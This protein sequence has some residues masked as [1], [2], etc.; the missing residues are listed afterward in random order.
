M[1]KREELDLINLNEEIDNFFESKPQKE[2]ENNPTDAVSTENSTKIDSYTILNEQLKVPEQISLLP[3]SP[4]F[5]KVSSIKMYKKVEKSNLSTNQKSPKKIIP[6]LNLKE[7]GLKRDPT[8]SYLPRI[9]K[10]RKEQ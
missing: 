7:T 4:P 2:T 10:R 1:L 5:T 8:K 9:I 6:N 3:A